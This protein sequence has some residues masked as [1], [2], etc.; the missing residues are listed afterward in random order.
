MS[1]DD[2]AFLRLH[3]EA[4]W[5]VHVPPLAGVASVT[6]PPE[7]RR[8]PWS[9]YLAR[10]G[11][12]FIALWPAGAAGDA[13]R[14]ARLRDALARDLEASGDAG[15]HR[16]VVL[17]LEDPA[18]APLA[19]PFAAR[20][21]ARHELALLETFD[22]GAASYYLLAPDRAP[23][24]AVVERGR[25]LAVAHSSRRSPAACELGIETR[26][27]ARRHGYALAVTRLWSAAVLA[28]G[29]TPIYSASA[30]KAASLALAAAA[31]YRVVAHAAYLF[32]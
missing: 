31:G 16:E 17:R 27:E 5:G 2:R 22:V 14:A 7:S 13:H 4:V 1:P 30:A 20:R 15:I 8:P 6:L 18:P 25:V 29:L 19:A 26:P 3:I 23:I 32:G 11:G 9:L 24:F 12:E 21:V 28:E 10:L